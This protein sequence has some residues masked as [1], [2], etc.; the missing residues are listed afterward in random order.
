MRC[1]LSF[2]QLY[3][4]EFNKTKI[5]HD[6]ELTNDL[7]NMFQTGVLRHNLNFTSAY[8]ITNQYVSTYQNRWILVDY[9]FFAA[10]STNTNG[11][12]LLSY[13]ALPSADECESVGLRIPNE[14]LGSDHLSIAAR[15]FLASNRAGVANEK[16]TYDVVGST[17]L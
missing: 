9:I 7:V 3:H 6:I 11:M 12:K 14:T 1:F 16:G 17:K 2:S 4:S 15:F 10:G 13:Y 5:S 8:P